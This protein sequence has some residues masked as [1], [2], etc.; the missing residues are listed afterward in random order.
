[1]TVCGVRASSTPRWR[2]LTSFSGTGSGRSVPFQIRGA[3][4]QVVYTMGYEGTCTFLFIC[5]GPSAQV[6]EP[7]TGANLAQFDLGEGSGQTRVFKSGAGVYQ[8]QVTPGSDSAHW[9]IAVD[10][11]Y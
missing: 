2:P 9:S 5:S 4:W 6:T 7:G 1:M 8:I 11:Y 3:R 10:D